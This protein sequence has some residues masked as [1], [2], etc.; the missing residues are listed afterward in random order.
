MPVEDEPQV[1]EIRVHGFADSG[2]A[3]AVQHPIA[4]MLCPEEEHTGPCDVPWE[5]T[6]GTHDEADPGDE[7]TVLVLGVHT[8]GVRAAAVADRVRA[9]VG[10]THP[11]VWGRGDPDR[12]EALIEQYRIESALPRD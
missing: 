3:F 2:E 5:F 7:R 4:R 8:L 6:V 10:D 11:V 12:F 1:H 9:L